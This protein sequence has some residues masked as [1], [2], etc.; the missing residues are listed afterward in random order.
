MK[1]V[2]HSHLYRGSTYF[3]YKSEAAV[4][5][6]SYEGVINSRF[7]SLQ[8][9]YKLAKHGFMKQF[10]G[11]WKVDPLYVDAQGIP[12]PEHAAD[13]VASIITLQQVA[14]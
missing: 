9:N 4:K 8:M 11:T 2:L 14:F 13:R 1:N 12:A 3:S 10:D 7:V 5:Q 6:I